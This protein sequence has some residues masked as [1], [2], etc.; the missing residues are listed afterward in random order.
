[1]HAVRCPPDKPALAEDIQR[2][3]FRVTAVLYRLT[4]YDLIVHI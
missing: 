4:R 1:M 3:D 2:Y